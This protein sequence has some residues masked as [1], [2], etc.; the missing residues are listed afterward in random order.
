MLNEF[1]IMRADMFAAGA[2]AAVKQVR[3]YT[4]EPYIVH[5]REVAG[6]VRTIPGVTTEMVQAA[7]LHDVMEDTG[8]TK[9]DVGESFSPRTTII[10]VGLTD[11]S[12]PEDGNRATR[13][14][15]DLEHLAI[16]DAETKTV[17]LCDVES[18]VKNIAQYDENFLPT[19]LREKWAQLMV[20]KEANQQKWND[21]YNLITFL[22]KEYVID[23]YRR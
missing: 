19:Y 17:R 15:I 3:K 7:L 6:I 11:I 10:V 1:E 13:K 8:V 16:Q 22:A 4:G 5:P 14:R 20:C 21:V 18:N 2:H 23:L 12:K 9:K